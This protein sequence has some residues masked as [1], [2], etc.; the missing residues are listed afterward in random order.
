MKDED[1]DGLLAGMNDALAYS[2][3]QANGI[4]IISPPDMKAIR[5]HTGLSQDKFA[6]V[7]GLEATAIRDWEQGRRKPDRA[8]QTLYRIIQK[9]P[10]AVRALISAA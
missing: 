6:T 9:D 8:A 1:F 4:R 5:K 3:G 10:E 2:R 7:Y